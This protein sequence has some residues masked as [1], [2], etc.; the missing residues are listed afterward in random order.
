MKRLTV[1]PIGG[2]C[3][4]LRVVLS[5]LS[6]ARS[7]RDVRVRVEWAKNSE[8]KA[9]FTD[10]F[11]PVKEENFCITRRRILHIP[12][13]RR[14]L[15]IPMRLRSFFY[16]AQYADFHLE[17]H[18]PIGTLLKPDTHIY[19][20]TCYE[21][22]SSS[23]YAKAHVELALRPELQQRVDCLAECFS[24]DTVGVH[25][26]R[27]DHALSIRTSPTEAFIAAMEAEVAENAATSFFLAT[28]DK[29]LKTT[30]QAAFPGRIFIQDTA[31]LRRNSLAGMQEAVV[32]LWCLARTKKILGSYWSS[33]SGTAAEIGQIPL[34]II[35]AESAEQLPSNNEETR[36]C[37]Q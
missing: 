32:D 28:D 17:K 37:D 31:L 9:A 12:D 20:S 8:C 18:P 23:P 4:R 30:L 26:R 3:N 29:A 16:D 33:F 1:V 11:L 15:H 14:N 13:R 24:P 35:G 10:L 22:F 19:L 34:Q 5:A 7:D 21:I 27:G 25:I 36:I 2:L 6:L